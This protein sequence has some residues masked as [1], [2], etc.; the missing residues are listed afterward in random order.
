MSCATRQAADVAPRN[1]C[2]HILLSPLLSDLEDIQALYDEPM[3]LRR[4]DAS[5]D[6]LGAGDEDAMVAKLL[7]VEELLLVEPT[8]I[9]GR[10]RTPR[11]RTFRH[12]GMRGVL[13]H[14][15]SRARALRG[16]RGVLAHGHFR[17][18]T[19]RRTG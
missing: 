12:A 19:L 8:K 11:A 15:H 2:A 17:A 16:S 4:H 5:P 14:G 13:A 9:K 6:T 7:G 10:S 3:S 18:R 1:G